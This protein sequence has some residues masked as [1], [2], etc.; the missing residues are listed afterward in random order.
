MYPLPKF[1]RRWF[2]FVAS[3]SLISL[4]AIPTGDASWLVYLAFLGFLAF[5]VPEKARHTH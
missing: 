1:D 5:L 2:G 4:A 3:F